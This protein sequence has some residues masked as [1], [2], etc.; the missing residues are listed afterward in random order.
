MLS[1]WR[2]I[3]ERIV[4]GDNIVITLV[5]IQGDRIR[6]GLEAPQ[7]V[8]IKRAELLEQDR[9]KATGG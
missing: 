9:T 2:K 6:L 8:T 5:S 3:N 1:L 4:I 7:Q